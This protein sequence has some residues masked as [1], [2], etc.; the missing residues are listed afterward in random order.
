MKRVSFDDGCKSQDGYLTPGSC[1]V[2]IAGVDADEVKHVVR[3]LGRC[4]QAAGLQHQALL[5]HY[6]GAS[7]DAG[8]VLLDRRMFDRLLA[9][10][11][12]LAKQEIPSRLRRLLLAVRHEMPLP[13]S[14]VAASNCTLV[15]L[16]PIAPADPREHWALNYNYEGGWGSDGLF[17]WSGQRKRQGHTEVCQALEDCCG[18]QCAVL[19]FRRATQRSRHVYVGRAR[20]FLPVAEQVPELG[21]PFTAGLELDT[22]GVFRTDDVELFPGWASP[23]TNKESVW[24]ALCTEPPPRYRMFG[25]SVSKIP[26]ECH[27]HAG[28][29]E[30]GGRDEETHGRALPVC[31]QDSAREFHGPLS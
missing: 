15:C 27:A 20:G 6:F 2:W 9:F 16:F 26:G 30:V 13:R 23:E 4:V 1:R 14:P 11:L 28:S 7:A 24:R 17:R 18:P 29:G 22:S 21:Q 5:L 31:V 12:G 3:L 19:V 10:F 8:P 25:Y